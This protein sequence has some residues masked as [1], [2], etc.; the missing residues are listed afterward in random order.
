MGAR[1]VHDSLQISGG[2]RLLKP[3]S[4]QRGRTLNSSPGRQGIQE[5]PGH[6]R[7]CLAA[8]SAFPRYSGKTETYGGNTEAWRFCRPPPTEVGKWQSRLWPLQVGETWQSALWKW[9]DPVNTQGDT[10]GET[11]AWEVIG[12]RQHVTC[13]CDSFLIFQV[14]V[15]D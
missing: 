12:Q 14:T 9:K 1:L 13:T 3:N 10:E 6:C 7:Q 8:V 5:Q 11:D 2:W 15:S 4:S